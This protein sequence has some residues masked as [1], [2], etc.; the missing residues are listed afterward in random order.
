MAKDKGG[1]KLVQKNRK[2]YFNYEILEK[3]EA[4]MVLLGSEV[5]SIR[6]GKVSIHES[7][8]KVRSNEVWV[9][10]MDISPY[11]HAGPLGHEPKRPRK[12]L[13]GKSEIHRLLSKTQEKGL[14]LIPL[15]LYFKGGYAKLE[16]GLGRGKA[17]YDKRATIKKREADREMRKR[18]MRR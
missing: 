11:A 5:K 12:L 15:S 10:N 9:I 3:L 2:A 7:Y 17:K 1:I 18:M 13:L 8:A 6:D 14:T 16:L 4:G